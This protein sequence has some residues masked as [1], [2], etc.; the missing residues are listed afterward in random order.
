MDSCSLL[1][2]ANPS[3]DGIL[4]DFNRSIPNPPKYYSFG[5]FF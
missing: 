4:A 5:R 2:L 3:I 1:Y